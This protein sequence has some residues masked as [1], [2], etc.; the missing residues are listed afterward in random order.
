M[1]CKQP[2]CNSE[3]S[4][5]GSPFR[6]HISA[7]TLFRPSSLVSLGWIPVC[8]S[9]AVRSEREICLRLWTMA[10]MRTRARD[11]RR[12]SRTSAKTRWDSE[13]QRNKEAAETEISMLSWCFYSSKSN[14]SYK[15]LGCT[16][17]HWPAEDERE[18]SQE[19]VRVNPLDRLSILQVSKN[20]MNEY[21]VKI[22]P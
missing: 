2:Q 17:L 12:N 19:I 14:S 18:L 3:N 11:R 15:E 6:S 16:E 1:S 22:Y 8:C 21:L 4:V 13:L 7:S 10:S 5:F 20:F 9:F